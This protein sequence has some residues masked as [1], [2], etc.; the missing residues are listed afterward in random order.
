VSEPGCIFCAIVADEAPS[1]R[2]AESDRALA[3]L[4][5]NPA[6]DGHTLVVPKRH[7]TDIWDLDP[8]DGRATWTLAQ[9]VAHLLRDRLR[10][11]GMT[12]AQANGRAGWQHVF[13]VHVHVIPRWE[14]D[15]LMQPWRMIPG[16]PVAVAAVAQR[17]SAARA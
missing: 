5:V 16:D 13:H 1:Y 2:V 17:L 10:A 11:D 15:G 6:T 8:D 4:D 14:G 3:F 9:E 12:L 7:A